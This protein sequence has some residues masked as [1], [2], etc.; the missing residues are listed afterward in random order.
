MTAESPAAL[1]DD[2]AVQARLP[3]LGVIGAGRVGTAIAR[4]ALASGYRVSLAGSADP[5]QIALISKVVAPGSRTRWTADAIREADVVILAIP[6]HR[7]EHLDPALFAGKIVIDSMNYWPPVDGALDEFDA[8]EHGSS[9]VVQQILFDSRVV[10][11]FNHVGYHD[12]EPDR[13]PAGHPERRG[14]AIAGDDATAVDAV[15]AI[16]DR[17][18]Y[19]PIRLPS[20]ADGSAL[21]PGGPIFGARLTAPDIMRAIDGARATVPSRHE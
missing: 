8:G 16:V 20:L 19:D 9:H 15:V 12:L 17:I 1:A 13:R 21:E 14:L 6:L 18:G 5:E 7:L 2:D 3:H 10:K 11:T 4:T